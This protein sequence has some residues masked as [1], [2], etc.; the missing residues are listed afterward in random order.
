MGVASFWSPA[1][2]TVNFDER[3]VSSSERGRL[4]VWKND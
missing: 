3:T 1:L 4:K 2:R